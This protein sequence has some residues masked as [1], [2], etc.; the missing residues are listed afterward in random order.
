LL[1]Q[2]WRKGSEAL[3]V[4]RNKIK[5]NKRQIRNKGINKTTA[6]ALTLRIEMKERSLR[7]SDPVLSA[8]NKEN[9]GALTNGSSM[10]K[11]ARSSAAFGGHG[12]SVIKNDSRRKLRK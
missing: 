4:R 3:P 1:A 8:Q 10:Q 5:I 12:G 6:S 9:R 2:T 11:D 7:C